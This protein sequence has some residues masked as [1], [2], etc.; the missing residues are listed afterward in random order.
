M[1]FFALNDGMDFMNNQSGLHLVTMITETKKTVFVFALNDGIDF[2][3]N[4]NYIKL[5]W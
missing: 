3:N 5:P 4:H 2:I 1:S